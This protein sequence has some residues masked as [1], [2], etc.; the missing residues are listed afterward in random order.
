M[1]KLSEMEF[2]IGE[3]ESHDEADRRIKAIHLHEAM[4]SNQGVY[5]NI[6]F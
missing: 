4:P 6:Q 5:E 3:K 2:S 1:L